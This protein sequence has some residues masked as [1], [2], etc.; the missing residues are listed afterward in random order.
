[1]TADDLR[2]TSYCDNSS[3]L[4]AE[5][6]LGTWIRRWYL[7]PDHDV[8][9]TLSEVREGLPFQLISKH[10]KN[11]DKERA[12]ADLPDPNNS[13]YSQTM[14]QRPHLM[15]S[16]QLTKSK[17]SY[18]IFV[19]DSVAYICQ[20]RRWSVTNIEEAYLLFVLG[21]VLP[22]PGVFVKFSCRLIF[23]PVCSS[24]KVNTY[25]AD[26]TNATSCSASS[27]FFC[28]IEHVAKILVSNQISFH[29]LQP[30]YGFKT[31][32]P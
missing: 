2:V 32:W 29:L 17:S 8:I 11:Q 19:K 4:K 22:I 30:P 31:F 16:V 12:F 23:Q 14:A 9:M 10:V 13:T 24:L 1:L 3:L 15:I 7:K 28:P 21:P 18:P 5:G 20:L 27:F 25:V 26:R 6:T